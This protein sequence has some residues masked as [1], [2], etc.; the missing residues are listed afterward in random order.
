M[1]SLRKVC[2]HVITN[3]NFFELGAE[4]N[5]Q[6]ILHSCLPMFEAFEVFDYTSYSS[7]IILTKI[8]ETSGEFDLHI[9]LT[10][11]ELIETISLTLCYHHIPN[12]V[13]MDINDLTY[14]TLRLIKKNGIYI[15]NPVIPHKII[16]SGLS[17]KE[18]RL[19]KYIYQ[20]YNTKF[21]AILF[22]VNHKTISAY[23]TKVMSKIGCHNK[24]AF[25]KAILNYYKFNDENFAQ[26]Y[27]CEI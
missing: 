11:N 12:V 18:K 22:G 16:M 25:Y 3:D 2:L 10:D 1:S 17:N 7:K 20:G 26:K 23:K 14:E 8:R 6:H 9:I 15:N 4:V 27:L 19:C 13:L 21:I 5:L 24:I